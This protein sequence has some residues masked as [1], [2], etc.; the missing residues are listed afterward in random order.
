VI[1]LSAVEND[2]DGTHFVYVCRN[3]G[4]VEKK[5]IRPGESVGTYVQADGLKE[6]E[7]VIVN[8]NPQIKE[9]IYVKPNA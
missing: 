8:P 3:D 6:G 5:Q 1:P 2:S 7:K 9:G 4:M